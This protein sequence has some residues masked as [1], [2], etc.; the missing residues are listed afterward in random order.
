MNDLIPFLLAFRKLDP[1]L[2]VEVG[3]DER[4]QHVRDLSE[5]DARLMVRVCL[6]DAQKGALIAL[7]PED[8]ALS[9][10]ERAARV[11]VVYQGMTSICASSPDPAQA[12]LP[13]LRVVH[14][15]DGAIIQRDADETADD[16][17]EDTQRRALPNE[18]PYRR[19]DTRPGQF[20][21]ATRD[22][23]DC[24]W[25][26]CP[27]NRDGEPAK[28]GRHCPLDVLDKEA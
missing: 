15:G 27:Q 8:M 14:H 25:A 23:G 17:A 12:R 2:Q 4:F 24:V 9:P 18:T 10:T 7:D 11:Y 26:D 19:V 28:T 20:C 21:H 16:L 13:R 5:A 6:R 3:L 1:N 22:D